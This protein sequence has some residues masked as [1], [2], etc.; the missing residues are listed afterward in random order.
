V[1][2]EEE[3][4]LLYRKNQASNHHLQKVVHLR[5]E[6]WQ[7]LSSGDIMIEVICQLELIIKALSLN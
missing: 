7:F 1:V 2:Q 3:L 5:R 4:L 6:T